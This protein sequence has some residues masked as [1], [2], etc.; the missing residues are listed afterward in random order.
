MKSKRARG[1]REE[2]RTFPSAPRGSFRS[3]KWE[4]L[5]A[6]YI[7]KVEMSKNSRAGVGGVDTAADYDISKSCVGFRY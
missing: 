6:G 5:L 1:T 7:L 3:R 2:T 4:S